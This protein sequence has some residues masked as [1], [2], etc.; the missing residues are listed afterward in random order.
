H[1]TDEFRRITE[2]YWVY[3][4]GAGAALLFSAV[5]SL[6]VGAVVVGQTLFSI[7]KEHLKELATLKALGASRAELSAFVAWQASVLAVLGGSAGA[8]MAWA[9]RGVLSSQ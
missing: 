3:G 4:T 7:T 8:A 5:F 2:S 9:L 1:T 6:V